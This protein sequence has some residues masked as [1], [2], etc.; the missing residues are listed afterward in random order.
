MHQQYRF[1][2]VT[3]A[4][5]ECAEELALMHDSLRAFHTPQEV[6]LV[7]GC[8]S[9]L[10]EMINGKSD[11]DFYQNLRTDPTIH[12]IPC[13]DVYGKINRQKMEKTRGIWY[14]TRH[15]D[16]MM[17]KANVMDFALQ[18]M[19]QD[20]G[21]SKT[22][23]SSSSS[24]RQLPSG[25]LYTDSDIT[26]FDSLHSMFSP[27]F[28]SS[29][30]PIL[31]GVSP[32]NIAEMDERLFGKFNGGMLF[33]AHPVVLWHWKR[34]TQTSRYFD[35]ASIEDVYEQISQTE[36]KES[37]CVFGPQVNYG[38]WRMFQT[39]KPSIEEEVKNFTLSQDRILY[40][41][42]PL[43]SVHTHFFMKTPCREIPV[44]NSLLKKWVREIVS[45]NKA[46][47]VYKRGLMKIL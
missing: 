1:Q 4:T 41:N 44:F 18:R 38:F 13:L 30:P 3:L 22:S 5:K 31:L 42:K 10:I 14:P 2:I 16:F 29:S 7:V 6:P 34:A 40:Q 11:D 20:E 15:C 32:H 12:W 27:F 37:V 46:N 8:S 25:V 17:E 19:K 26:F 43:Q 28:S 9:E 23:T 33:A 45:K 35:Q 36:G 21:E 39:P 24:Q 47:V